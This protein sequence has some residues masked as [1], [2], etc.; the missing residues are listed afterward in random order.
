MGR[1]SFV[2]SGLMYIGQRIKVV[3]YLS[4]TWNICPE[5]EE[6]QDAMITLMVIQ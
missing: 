2:I 1:I 3:F 4:H 6:T 5:M